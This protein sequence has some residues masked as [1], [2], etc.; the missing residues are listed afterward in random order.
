MYYNNR[1][2]RA[3]PESGINRNGLFDKLDAKAG[4][5]ITRR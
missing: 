1:N 5:N 4:M 3:G 2:D